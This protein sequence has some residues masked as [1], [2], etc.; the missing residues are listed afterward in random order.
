MI[1]RLRRNSIIFKCK[2]IRG[3]P[4]LLKLQLPQRF[5][6]TSNDIYIIKE[7]E[8]I[9]NIKADKNFLHPEVKENELTGDY[10]TPIDKTNSEMELEI[11]EPFEKVEAEKLKIQIENTIN[12][13][14]SHHEMINFGKNSPIFTNNWM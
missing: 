7:S 13:K 2:K 4:S 9:C 1:L 6:F 3:I 8:N 11:P 14:I 5:D 12:N 10:G